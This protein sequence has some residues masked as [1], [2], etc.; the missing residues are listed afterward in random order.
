MDEPFGALDPVTRGALQGEIARIHHIS[1]RTIVLVTHD[2]DEALLLADRILLLDGGRLV[3]QGTPQ[4]LLLRPASARFFWR[5]RA[6]DPPAVAGGRRPVGSSG[7]VAAGATDPGGD[8]ATCGVVR[9]YRPRNRSLAGGGRARG[10]RG[11]AALQ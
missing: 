9:V 3:Q 10:G 6:G 5:R 11:R 1:R 2:I 7:G 4:Q 8:V